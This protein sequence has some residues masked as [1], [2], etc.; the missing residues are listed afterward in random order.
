MYSCSECGYKSVKWMGKCPLCS[1]WETFSEEKEVK[2]KEGGIAREKI[3]PKRLA[4]I[5]KKSF[6]KIITG[7]NEF[8]R[9]L[10]G[11][12]VQGEVILIGGEPGVG[13]STLLL[14]VGA[15][16]SKQGKTLYVSAEESPQQIGLRAQRL[17]S[18]F[19]DL[20]IVGED[21]LSSII[22]I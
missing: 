6:P 12:V 20:Y 3:A 15:K 13:K 9:I 17:K 2:T 7:I 4:D 8:D 10:G 21:D 18:E 5:G 14:E 22:H 1:G 11:G 16:V 19:D